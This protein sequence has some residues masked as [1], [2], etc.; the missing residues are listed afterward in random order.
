MV[1]VINNINIILNDAR[2][3]PTSTTP[4]NIGDTLLLVAMDDIIHLDCVYFVTGRQPH[5]IIGMLRH[6][7][8]HHHQGST[9]VVRSPMG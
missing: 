6:H 7:H 5:T 3:S 1:V 4:L 9:A 8:H 2:Y